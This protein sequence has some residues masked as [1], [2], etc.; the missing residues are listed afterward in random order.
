[1]S[2]LAETLDIPEYIVAFFLAAIGTSLP[3][4]V[5]T[6]TAIRQGQKD[7]AIGN[8]LGATFIDSTLSIGIGPLI[9][10][11]LVTPSLVVVGSVGAA[12]A[13]GLVAGILALRGK[14]DW[15]TGILFILIYLAF[16][17]LLLTRM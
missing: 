16:Y 7:L 1:M 9:A 11:V 4:L 15:R 5:V 8:A 10:P 12:V 13:I 14:H 6:L 17:F 3:E 2:S